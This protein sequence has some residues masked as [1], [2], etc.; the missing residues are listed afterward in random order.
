MAIGVA[1][2]V[3]IIIILVLLLFFPFYLLGFIR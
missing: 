3:V 2:F 1:C